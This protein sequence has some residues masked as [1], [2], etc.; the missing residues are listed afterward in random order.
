[1]ALTYL[2]SRNAPVEATYQPLFVIQQRQITL[3]HILCNSI[4]FNSDHPHRRYNPLTGEWILCSPQRAK[5][6]W[7]GQMEKTSGDET[8]RH[9]PKNPLCPGVTRPNGVV[10]P[11]NYLI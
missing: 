8:P 7:M 3:C 10:S 1:M 4:F 11:E 6:P 2:V 5:R 9:D